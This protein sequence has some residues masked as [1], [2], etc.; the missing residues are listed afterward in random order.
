MARNFIEDGRVLQYLNNGGA[1]IV[2][3]EA[4]LVGKLMG[5]ALV[6]IPVGASG[7]VVLER[8]WELPKAA[9]AVPQGAQLFWDPA[10]GAL[11]TEAANGETDNVPAGKAFATAA[12]DATTVRIKINA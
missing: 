8:V 5:V 4:V 11:T 6:D 3:G 1:D 7:S 12:A 9:G 10:A 2:S